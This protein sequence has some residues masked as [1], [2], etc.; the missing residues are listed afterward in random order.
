MIIVIDGYNLIKNV[1]PGRAVNEPERRQFLVQFGAYAKRKKHSL[2]VVFDGGPYEWVHKENEFGVQVMYSGSRET[3][4]EVIIKY[5]H[6]HRTKE[7]L[8]V[9]SDHEIC[10]A[11]SKLEMPSIGSLDFYGLVKEA[12]A[13]RMAASEFEIEVHDDEAQ[14][15]DALMHE[16]GRQAA[17]KQDD[18]IPHHKRQRAT[19]QL[20]KKERALVQRLKKL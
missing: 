10:V 6:V 14:D 16:A 7:L 11:A 1:I 5:L 2:V 18:I 3:A 9:S 15:L 20:S 4:D 17:P 19:Q 8:L 13:Q 12:L